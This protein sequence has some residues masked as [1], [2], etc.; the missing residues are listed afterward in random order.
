VSGDG[1]EGSNVVESKLTKGGLK[2]F[3]SWCGIDRVG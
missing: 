3:D 1:V 2:D